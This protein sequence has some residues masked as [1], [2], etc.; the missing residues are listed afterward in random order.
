MQIIDDVREL[1][2]GGRESLSK[3]IQGVNLSQSVKKSIDSVLSTA[4][5]KNISINNR[6]D[7]EIRV[8]SEINSLTSAVI[9]NLLINAIKFSHPN[10]KVDISSDENEH[11]VSLHVRDYGIGMP[12]EVTEH[13][14]SGRGNISRPGT[15]GESGTGF[16]LRIV[17]KFMNIYPGGNISVHSCETS[18]NRGTEVK[19]QFKKAS[20]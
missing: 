16:G 4:T 17:K 20:V 2:M 1:K 14:F 9:T 5:E 18:S 12:K 15:L 13:L 6:V 10:S 19:L 8:L 3:K 11:S 7:P